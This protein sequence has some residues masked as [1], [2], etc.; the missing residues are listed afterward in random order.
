MNFERARFIR[1]GPYKYPIKDVS[2]DDVVGFDCPECHLTDTLD[3]SVEIRQF[4]PTE[5]VIVMLYV[6][7][8]C[9]HRFGARF[10]FK[11]AAESRGLR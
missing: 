9:G 2:P 1:I 8:E 10:R 4:G 7:G 3:F 6:C 11:W 5:D